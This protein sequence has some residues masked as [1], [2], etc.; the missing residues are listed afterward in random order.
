MI[1]KVNDYKERLIA[2]CNNIT[3]FFDWDLDREAKDYEEKG[4]RR[5]TNTEDLRKTVYKARMEAETNHG[6]GISSLYE[7]IETPRGYGIGWV[8]LFGYSNAADF[9]IDEIEKQREFALIVLSLIKLHEDWETNEFKPM[10]AG[11]SKQSLV[12]KEFV[13]PPAVLEAVNKLVLKEKFKAYKY[14]DTGE[15]INMNDTFHMSNIIGFSSD[16]TMWLNHVQCQEEFLNKQDK[17][18]LFVTMFG[19]MDEVHPLYSSWLFTIHKGGTIWIV[20]DQVDFDNPF[21]K[22]ARLERRSVWRDRDELYGECDLPYDLFHDIDKIKGS[23]DKIAKNDAY[24]REPFDF[25][26]I[27]KEWSDYSKQVKIFEKLFKQKLDALGVNYDMIYDESDGPSMH[28]KIEAG[29]ARLNGKTVAYCHPDEII[30]YKRPEFFFKQFNELKDAQKAFA[31][32]L[33]NEIVQYM[34]ADNLN[35]E[36]IMLASDFI[37]MKMIEGAKIDPVNPTYMEYWNDEHKKIFNELLETLENGKKKKSTALALHKFDLVKKSQ[38]YDASW[39]TLPEKL[40]SLAEWTVLED[41]R[42]LLTS[43]VHELSKMREDAFD[44]L[45]ETTNKNRDEIIARMTLAKD[46]QFRTKMWSSFS[47]EDNKLADA[48]S[49]FPFTYKSRTDRHRGFGIGKTVFDKAACVVCDNNSSMQVKRIHVE[50][51]RELMW[52]FGFEDRN[53][54]HK[55]F[56]QYR[57]TSGMTPYDGNSLLDQTHPYLRLKDP[58]SDRFSNGFNID[59]YMCGVCY[60]KI[61]QP[62]LLTIEY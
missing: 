25:A 26:P 14:K 52:L 30:V 45:R 15:T 62:D 34:S 23:N 33:V 55:Y 1:T 19:K 31:V 56:R 10:I 3:D 6:L 51:Y 22:H 47:A 57:G 53:E 48:G 20:T 49:V 35:T 9:T 61:K 32:L 38:H 17:D 58:C 59:L 54:L 43:K 11:I 4:R 37:E 12:D 16:L 46:I 7:R 21:Q 8:D 60:K 28:V 40:Q 27:H 5:I 36:K 29:Y 50:H 13:M 42:I 44:W 41:E 18:Q 2:L 24:V 39:L